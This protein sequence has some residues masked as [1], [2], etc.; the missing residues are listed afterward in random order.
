MNFFRGVRNALVIVIP[1][2]VII[3]AINCKAQD[4]INYKDAYVVTK[5]IDSS[6]G[7]VLDLPFQTYHQTIV[8]NGR[9]HY[10]YLTND[11][12]GKEV[13]VY[14]HYAVKDEAAVKAFKGYLGEKWK[15]VSS[16]SSKYWTVTKGQAFSIT[17]DKGVTTPYIASDKDD[18]VEI[19]PEK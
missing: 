12:I 13:L 1:F 17:D 9:N 5:V 11:L 6:N 3:F 18:V 10:C 16:K 14:I 8:E 2:W 7:A 19:Y 15:D 4:N